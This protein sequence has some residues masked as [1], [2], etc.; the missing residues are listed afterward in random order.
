MPAAGNVTFAINADPLGHGID[1]CPTGNV[2]LSWQNRTGPFFAKF[3]NLQPATL[4]T[5]YIRS[6][7]SL[8]IW[9]FQ[10]S[11]LVSIARNVRELADALTAD[12]CDNGLTSAA[13]KSFFSGRFPT[14]ERICAAC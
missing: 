7:D 5:S 11:A 10:T 6:G 2:P 3:C 12:P 9:K 14:Y 1:V 8:L 4:M 13:S